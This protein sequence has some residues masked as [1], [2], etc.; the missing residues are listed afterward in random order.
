MLPVHWQVSQPW[1][2][3]KRCFRNRFL[4]SDAASRAN[5]WLYSATF[6]LQ[7]GVFPI[8][9]V[10]Q[11]AITVLKPEEELDVEFL[12]SRIEQTVPVEWQ[13]TLRTL[14]RK[15][16]GEAL[17]FEEILDRA[18]SMD[19]RRGIN[20]D[21]EPDNLLPPVRFN[22]PDHFN[23]RP[24]ENDRRPARDP[25]RERADLQRNRKFPRREKGKRTVQPNRRT[26]QRR[27]HLQLR[28][29]GSI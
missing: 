25:D 22:T 10:L 24:F 14:F 18:S 26:S 29:T 4:P 3:W 19:T 5:A 15:A 23:R 2:Q 7:R 16:T 27:K 11:R 20:N 17:P 6:G 8:V 13:D 21:G 9:R 28:Q 12:V 1:T